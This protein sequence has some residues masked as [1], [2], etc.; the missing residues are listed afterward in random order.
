MYCVTALCRSGLII[1]IAFIVA[2]LTTTVPASA[3]FYVTASAG[4]SIGFP[5]MYLG[6]KPQ[7]SQAGVYDGLANGFE[8]G[9]GAGYM[10]I[11]PVGVEL[12][13]L[14]LAGTETDKFI[15]GTGAPT[16]YTLSLSAVT[17]RI[18]VSVRLSPSVNLY[19]KFGPY[20]AFPS[21]EEYSESGSQG[22][23]IDENNNPIGEYRAT[24]EGGIALGYSSSAGISMKTSRATLFAEVNVASAGWGPDRLVRSSGKT[25]AIY[26]DAL[27]PRF[28]ASSMVLKVGMQF[29]F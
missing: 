12:S 15:R 9:A 3:Q 5:S 1:P 4:Y 26:S 27:K 13:G 6:T 21:L 20:L 2:L 14:Y 16:T 11:P 19:T 8:F 25:P 10:F 17:P 29:N 7:N 24:Y 18:V 23:I 22:V 28:D